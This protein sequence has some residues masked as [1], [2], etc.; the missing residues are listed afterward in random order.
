MRRSLATAV[1][2][3]GIQISADV[4]LAQRTLQVD[5]EVAMRRGVPRLHGY[6]VNDH[7]ALAGN[8]QLAVETLDAGG[9]VV[10]R[11]VHG[12]RGSAPAFGRLYY[13]LPLGETGASYRVTVVS[14]AWF[15]GGGGP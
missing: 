15:G 9:A 2:L 6:I 5:W 8:I 13:E 12:V 4:A 3:I 1:L 11:A 14:A 7:P 10:S